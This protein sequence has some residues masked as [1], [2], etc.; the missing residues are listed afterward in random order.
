MRASLWRSLFQE[1]GRGHE[2]RPATCS[3]A[4]TLPTRRGSRVC[5]DIL[6]HSNAVFWLYHNIREFPS[7]Q[8]MEICNGRMGLFLC[9]VTG[10]RDPSTGE[11]DGGLPATLPLQSKA[12]RLTA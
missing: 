1:P 11:R 4:T 10:A 12:A 8:I 2:G 9:S 5:S 3:G 6:E 7:V